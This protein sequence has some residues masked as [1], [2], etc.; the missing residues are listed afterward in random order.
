MRV[1][2]CT[3]KVGRDKNRTRAQGTRA[4]GGGSA[5]L[6]RPSPTTERPAASG[7]NCS[8]NNLRTYLRASPV[9]PCYQRHNIIQ[10]YSADSRIQYH[11]HAVLYYSKDK[12]YNMVYERN[13]KSIRSVHRTYLNLALNDPVRLCYTTGRSR[14][15]SCT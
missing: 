7:F 5:I 8:N 13:E 3:G 11:P 14:E 12:N 1:S 9:A 15:R 4:G 6:T 2:V 10:F